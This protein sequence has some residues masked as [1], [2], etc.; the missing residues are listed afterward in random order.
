MQHVLI[1]IHLIIVVALV[2]VVLLQRSEGGGLGMGSGGGGG[3]GGFMTGRGQA[4]A[5]TRATAILAGLFFLTSIILA[6]MANTGRTQRSILDGA[7]ATSAPAVPGAPA[8]PSAPNAGGGVLDQL[9]Q[10]QNQNQGG[11]QP[12][13]PAAPQQ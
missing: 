6:V 11:A 2:G 4:N 5:L 9:R 8:G 13:T 3:V 1:V 12:P 10:M 7:P